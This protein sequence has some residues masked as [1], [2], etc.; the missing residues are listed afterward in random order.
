[1]NTMTKQEPARAGGRTSPE[2][3]YASG[4]PRIMQNILCSQK[5]KALPDKVRVKC[6]H[7]WG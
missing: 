5:L 6:C 2:H 7:A 3:V 1:M 4:N